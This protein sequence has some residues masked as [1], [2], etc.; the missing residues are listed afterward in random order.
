LAGVMSHISA[1]NGALDPR[2]QAQV[3]AFE[4]VLRKA[5]SKQ[6]LRGHV[7]MANSASIFTNLQ[8][9]YDTVRPGISAYGVLPGGLPGAR[10]LKPVMSLCSQ[11]VFLKDVPA[12]QQVG[13]DSTWTA[14]HS[15]RIATLPLGYND[16][17]SWR[18]GNRGEVLIRGQRAPIIGRVSMDYITLDVTHIRDVA[19]GDGA[20]LFGRC[21]D[22][23]LSVEEVAHKA[24]TIPY[25]ITCSVG[26]R[27]PRIFTGGEGQA[28]SALGGSRETGIIL[29]QDKSAD[30]KGSG[31]SLPLPQA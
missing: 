26:K 21:G 27:V 14:Q 19:V 11:V 12:G 16:G 24:G 7:H 13:Y 29:D 20:L 22:Q 1:P 23:R 10:E 8:P 30:Q 2:S 9:G 18:L 3:E 15:T 4:V 17:V 25:E 28:P 31:D 5:R 6:L